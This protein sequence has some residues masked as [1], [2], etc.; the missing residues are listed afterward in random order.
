MLANVQREMG[1]Y[2]DAIKGYE[3]VLKIKQ[4]EFGVLVAL[5]LP[6]VQKVR[7]AADRIS[8]AN[9]LKQIGLAV[10]NFHDDWS[11]FPPMYGGFKYDAQGNGTAGGPVTWWLLPYME[12]GNWYNEAHGYVYSAV[13]EWPGGNAAFQ[14]IKS[15]LCPSDPSRDGDTQAWGGG[16]A[17][18][19]YGANYQV[20]GKP[21]AG[22]D[23]NDM[24]GR[25]SIA[26]IVDG[27][28][29]TIMFAEKYARCGND[30]HGNAKNQ[31]KELHG[32]LKSPACS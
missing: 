21:D 14:P 24:E 25:N 4:D 12:Q 22:D 3:S 20:F 32:S 13:P 15:Y 23:G 29:N 11:R 19:N 10:H 1:S 26:T 28:S 2:E 18:G 16:W 17:F 30:G 7:A 31:R 8:C 5:L 9:N 27:T 6:A